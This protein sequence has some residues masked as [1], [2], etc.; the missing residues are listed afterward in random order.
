MLQTQTAGLL[1]MINSRQGQLLLAKTRRCHG[2][3]SGE[4]LHLKTAVLE[5]KSDTAATQCDPSI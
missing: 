2:L 4:H 3:L 1:L 5:N